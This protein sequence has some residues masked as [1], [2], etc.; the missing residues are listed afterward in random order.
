M[1]TRK[2][3][4]SNSSTTS[5]V[6]EVC[7]RTEVEYDS[8]SIEDLEMVRC[9]NEHLF[10]EE[11]MQGEGVGEN[12]HYDVPETCCPICSFQVFSQ[13]DLARYLKKVTNISRD[14]AFAQVKALNKRRRKLYDNEYNMYVMI[15]SN[16]N[17]ET[18]LN[19]VKEKFVTYSEFRKYLRD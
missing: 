5:F 10:C 13:F 3:F 4:V 7:G 15:K 17:Q 19:E 6:C 16:I 2:G 11:E 8:V 18:L 9:V 1:K 14:E 12:G